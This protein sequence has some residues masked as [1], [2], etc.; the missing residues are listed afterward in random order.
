MLSKD[1]IFEKVKEVLTAGFGIPREQLGPS[2]RLVEDLD[3]D[4]LDLF[5]LMV[6]L[7]EETG[8]EV[9]EDEVKSIRT[10]Q[11]IVDVIHRRVESKQSGQA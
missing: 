9:I 11:D 2:A 8:E 7:E 3:L 1:E 10:I 5:D 4:S 6:R